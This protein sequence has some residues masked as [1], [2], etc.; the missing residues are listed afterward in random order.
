ML[1]YLYYKEIFKEIPN[2]ITLGIS[3]SGCQIHCKG[4]HSRELWEDKGTPL[5]PQCLELLLK[6]HQG[7]TC[8]CLFGGEHDM[9][10]LIE[11]FKSIKEHTS[12]KTAW[13]AGIDW[14]PYNTKMPNK[15][16]KIQSILQ[17][18]DLI[19]VGHYDQDLGGLDSPTTNQRLYRLNKGTLIDI[20]HLLQ[21]KL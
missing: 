3:I 18:L 8:V 5:T 9:D 13:Y 10:S 16:P 12:L 19:K 17:Y 21:N 1:K 15:F 14:I 20:T 2:E 7:I 11:L 6:K 4:C